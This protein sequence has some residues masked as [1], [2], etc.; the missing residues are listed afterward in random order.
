MIMRLPGVF[1]KGSVRNEPV[2]IV[3]VMPTILDALEWPRDQWPAMEGRSLLGLPIPMDRPVYAE[4]MR[5]DGQEALFHA[6]DPNFDFSPFSRRL[7]SIQ[8]GNLK[9][10]V[11][12]PGEREL[13]DLA[14]DPDERI[15]LASQHPAKA[16]QL[17]QK[18]REWTQQTESGQPIK[19]E[20]DKQTQK[21]L[22]K[23]G[24]ID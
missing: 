4:Y 11:P 20:L 15:N 21:A 22:R 13:Y 10:I 2:Q 19:V 7:T 5:P 12:D 9:L 8:I 17:E 18:L 14:V 23:L 24:Y 16:D 6:I 3:D 1:P